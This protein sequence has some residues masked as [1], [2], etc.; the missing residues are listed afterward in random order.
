LASYYVRNGGWKR[1]WQA[2][3]SE[4]ACASG[5]DKL[6]RRKRGGQ[7]VLA[8]SYVGSGAA[9]G[10]GRLVRRKRSGEAVLAG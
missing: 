4:T 9:S 3:T 8:G 2:S 5:F 6:V 7:A 1:F 10:F